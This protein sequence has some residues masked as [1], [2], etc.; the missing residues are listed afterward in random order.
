MPSAH[1]EG[2]RAMST[3]KIPPDVLGCSRK[4]AEYLYPHNADDA[5]ARLLALG[6]PGRMLV[7]AFDECFRL[8]DWET[9]RRLWR[10]IESR[11]Q[12]VELAPRDFI[13]PPGT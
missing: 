1:A 13:K 9:C 3:L 4:L 11:M 12:G 10:H 2:V 6:D 8:G 7:G 5:P